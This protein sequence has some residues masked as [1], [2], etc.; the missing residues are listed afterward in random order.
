M[1]WMSKQKLLVVISVAMFV[2]FCAPAGSQRCFLCRKPAVDM[3]ISL[4]LGTTRSPEFIAKHEHYMISIRAKWLLPTEELKCRMGFRFTWE[5]HTQ[6][7]SGPVIG[8]EWSALEGNRIVAQGS[9]S[10]LSD[11]FAV[12]ANYL[13]R[14]IGSFEGESKHKYSVLLKFTQ[15]GSVLNVAQPHLYVIYT[16][17]TDF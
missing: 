6:C 11:R 15:D 4:A 7:A 9:D 12:S 2:F 5:D 13:V 14:D 8:V 1:N 10:G 16:K 3:P 17:P